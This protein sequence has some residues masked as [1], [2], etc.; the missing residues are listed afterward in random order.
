[1]SDL[2]FEDKKSKRQEAS[3]ALQYKLLQAYP[4]GLMLALLPQNVEPQKRYK[5]TPYAWK[6]PCPEAYR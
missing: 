3:R 2:S 4:D 1:M 6:P 5:Y